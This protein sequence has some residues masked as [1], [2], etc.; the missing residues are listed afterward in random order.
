MALGSHQPIFGNEEPA[1]IFKMA[2]QL[3]LSNNLLPMPV[4]LSTVQLRLL[5]SGL[6]AAAVVAD[7]FLPPGFIAGLL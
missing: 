2:E 5:L 3:V 4:S 6:A 1:P 7:M